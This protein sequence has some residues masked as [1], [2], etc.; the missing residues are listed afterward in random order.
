[1]ESI[2]A[3]AEAAIAAKTFPGCVVGYVT[4]DGQTECWPYGHLTYDDGAPSVLTD[5]IYDT[6][7]LTKSVAT[8]SVALHLVDHGKLSIDDL[9]VDYVPEF[10]NNYREQVT[11]KHLLTYAID[12]YGLG[13]FK[14][15]IAD[16]L[17]QIILTHDFVEPPGTV[18][19]YTNVPA[20]LLGLVIERIAGRPLDVL[21]D[22]LFY[23][24]LR[25]SRTTFHPD[26]FDKLLIPPTE[27]DASWRRRVV[28]G[29]VHDESASVCLADGRVVGQAG[30]FSTAPDLLRFMHMILRGGEFD[31]RRYFS[32][33][34]VQQMYSNQLA[35]I[36]ES[37]GLGWEL[38]QP[39]YMGTSC[40]PTTFGKTG[41]TGTVL[42]ADVSRRVALVILSNRTY[43]HR[44]PDA[45]A[46]H[47]FRSQVADAVFGL[48]PVGVI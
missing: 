25:M 35:D 19:K 45:R 48:L 18:F 22:E 33:A 37:N 17:H 12:G 13:K 39:R 34:T 23:G 5:T 30:L 36:G 15:R 28:Q 6:A 43:P 16:E 7:S 21:A 41:F 9:L 14:D 32:E 3:L 42:I 2:R 31:G 20:Y 11:I 1:M 24:P 29:E 26:R 10:A 47:S 4:T 44:P 40:T 27:I 46:I 38:N 8:A